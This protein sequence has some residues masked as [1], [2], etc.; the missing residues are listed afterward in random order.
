MS[1]GIY[2]VAGEGDGTKAAPRRPKYVPAL[3]VDW[4]AMD[5]GGSLVFL[6]RADL[7]IAQETTLGLN[8]DFFA[9]PDLD[10]QL[11]A[12]QVSAAQTRL[13]NHG[14]PAGWITTSRTWRQVLR[15]VAGMFQLSQRAN[16]SIVT[17]NLDL[18]L[19]QIPAGT[20]TALQDAA[21]AFGFDLAGI[22]GATLV[23]EALRALAVQ[24][25]DR[26]KLGDVDL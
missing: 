1:A 23:R 10:T 2:I 12:G 26:M 22:T 25:V 4:T 6:V 15:V 8:S 19:N 9:V 16:V 3:G 13:E 20:R 5:F 18:R 11:T 24:W 21:T 7:T 14:I 17:A